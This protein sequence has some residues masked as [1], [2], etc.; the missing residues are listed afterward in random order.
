[1][2]PA[3][4]LFLVSPQSET[5]FPWAAPPPPLDPS[6]LSYDPVSETLFVP[7]AISE[8]LRLEDGTVVPLPHDLLGRAVAEGNIRVVTRDQALALEGLAKVRAPQSGRHQKRRLDLT[9]HPIQPPRLS[10]QVTEDRRPTHRIRS[11]KDKTGR[12]LLSR[13]TRHF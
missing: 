10:S 7:S 8:A 13:F 6:L 12:R 1:M 2:F 5:V 9:G 4:N 11:D 3:F